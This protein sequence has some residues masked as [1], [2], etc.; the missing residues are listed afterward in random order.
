MSDVMILLI[1]GRGN[2]TCSNCG[3]NEEHEIRLY[4]NDTTGKLEVQKEC[5][6]YDY[7]AD[8]KYQE[9]FEG[10]LSAK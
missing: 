7:D 2:I 8:E 10:S 5:I 3:E 4:Y 1:T 9:D 6:C